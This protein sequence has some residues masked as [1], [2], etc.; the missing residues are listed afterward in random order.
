MD[1]LSLKVEFLSRA[2]SQCL[3]CALPKRWGSPAW[4]AWFLWAPLESWLKGASPYPSS[5]ARKEPCAQPHRTRKW[6][7]GGSLGPC[8]PRCRPT[9]SHLG[10]GPQS[11]MFR[12][13]GQNANLSPSHPPHFT[14]GWGAGR[15]AAPLKV[16][17]GQVAGPAPCPQTSLLPSFGLV[18]EAPHRL[19]RTLAGDWRLAEDR[20]LE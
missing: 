13:L 9:L 8:S 15:G 5:T 6:L 10:R 12:S 14:E 7:A 1:S 3:L 16:R 18:Q 11:G 17:G 20:A 2:M 4:G 19:G